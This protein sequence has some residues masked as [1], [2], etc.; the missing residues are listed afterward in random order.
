MKV[1]YPRTYHLPFS[2]GGTSDDKRLSDVSHF[3]G[4]EIVMTEKRDGENST[5]S[6]DYTHARSLDSV[7]HP[8]RHWLKGF[9][10]TISYD[11]PEDWRICGENLY[12]E[13]SLGY[14]NLKTYFEVFSIWNEKN[15]CLSWDD[16][17]DWCKLLGLTLVPVLY[18]GI[19]DENFL[20]N[21][22]INTKIQEG[23]VI[24]LAS[25]FQ[26]EDFETSVA[27]WVRD[28]HISTDE[29][30]MD[31]PVIPNKLIY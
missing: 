12:A 25:G 13:H 14:D 27:K 11:I 1:K 31:K 29:H 4:K 23:Y 7:D 19:F 8:S 9:W 18:R 16:T 5:I 21:Y 10:S 6:R 20:K 28:G 15:E 26:Y 24:R 17:D 3:V 30:W 2:Q 22:K